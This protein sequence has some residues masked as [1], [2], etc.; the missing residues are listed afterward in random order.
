MQE[1]AEL[2]LEREE[3]ERVQ[4]EREAQVCAWESEAA[5]GAVQAWAPG[6]MW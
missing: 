5:A 1:A 2:Q 4:R 3:Q 6:C